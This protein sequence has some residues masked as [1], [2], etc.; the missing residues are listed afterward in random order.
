MKLSKLQLTVSSQILDNFLTQSLIQQRNDLPL[1]VLETQLPL[2]DV[3]WDVASFDAWQAVVRTTGHSGVE[4]DDGASNVSLEAALHI[5]KTKKTRPPIQS[6]FGSVILVNALLFRM[7]HVAIYLSNPISTWTPH[8]DSTF[9]ISH[10]RERPCYLA[11]IPTFANWRNSTC[12]CLDLLHWTALSKSSLAG[13]FEDDTFLHLHL[14]RLIL[15][16]PV[17]A[18]TEISRHWPLTSTG[19]SDDLRRA[20]YTTRTWVSRDRYK[21]RLAVIHAGAIFWHVRRF[22][23]DIFIQP[24]AVFLAT[25]TLWTYVTFEKVL[26]DLSMTKC[27]KHRANEVGN[28]SW[29]E[30]DRDHRENGTIEDSQDNFEEGTDPRM[31][32][33]M[34]LDRPMD[35]ELVQYFINHGRVLALP[36]EGISNILSPQGPSHIVRSGIEILNLSVLVCPSTS[37]YK[38]I[39]ENLFNVAA[40]LPT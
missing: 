4:L 34:T 23:T 14:A 40:C 1:M 31:P 37:R 26:H 32:Q 8:N 11:E 39:L 33:S 25:I 36:M 18:V 35:D 7:S 22:S 17:N 3:L 24:T 12:D 2:S 6:T 20:I 21:A 30:I 38:N 29:D 5:L 27:N 13:G 16:V 19:N 28:E 10:A 9:E 15:L